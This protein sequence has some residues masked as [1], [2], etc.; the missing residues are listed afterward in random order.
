[1]EK[2]VIESKEEMMNVK[3]EIEREKE[4]EEEEDMGK[5]RFMEDEGNEIMKKIKDERIY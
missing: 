1:M 3:D 4:E 2:R 5:K